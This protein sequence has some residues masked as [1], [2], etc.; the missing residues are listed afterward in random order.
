MRTYILSMCDMRTKK[1]TRFQ[2]QASSFN[3][4]LRKA[5]QALNGFP[6]LQENGVGGRNVSINA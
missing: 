6:G 2:C 5:Q 1:Q 3:E 4:A